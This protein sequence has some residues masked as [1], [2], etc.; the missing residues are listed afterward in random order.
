MSLS[1]LKLQ[2]RDFLIALVTLSM[3]AA[4][5]ASC[6]RKKITAEDAE[7]AEKKPETRSWNF[8]EVDRALSRAAT[9]ALGDREGAVLVMDPQTGR[10]RAVVNPRLAFEQSFPP[11]STIKSFTALTA[12][13]G[14]LIDN[15]SRNQ[16]RGRFTSESI[17]VVCSH[18]KS[19]SPFSL[20][21]AL[22][23]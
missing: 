23:Y 14:G 17:D 19:K 4:L 10:L 21:Q 8:S 6:A 3:G 13:R 18:P 5:F 2:L 22:A 11:G 20:S 1:R 15:E 9:E 12:M 7:N 16:C